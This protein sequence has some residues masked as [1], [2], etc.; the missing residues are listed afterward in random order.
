VYNANFYDFVTPGSAA[1][2]RVVLPILWDFCRPDSVI[3][4]GCGGGGWARTA[5]EFGATRV[6]GVDGS[7]VEATTLLIP[8]DDFVAHDLSQPLPQFDRF[9]LAVNLEVAEHLPEQRAESLVAD[10]CRLSDVVLFSAAIP[11]QSGVNHVNEQWPSYWV[12]HFERCGY[13][14]IDLVRPR[15]WEDPTVEFWYRQNVFVAVNQHRADL[16][17]R[18]G[19][20]LPVAPPTWDV[21]HPDMLAQQLQTARRP[22]STR[23]AGV[24]FLRGVRRAAAR[25]VS[26]LRRARS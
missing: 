3:D 12:R 6:I 15:V 13:V 7:Y 26:N 9:D 19:E 17:E 18:A 23:A 8:I 11:G 5:R 25:R 21:V 2:A 20:A 10:L 16:R 4:V 24:I 1:S 22:P 14:C